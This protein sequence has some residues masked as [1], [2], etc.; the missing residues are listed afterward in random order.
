M[1]LDRDIAQVRRFSRFYTQHIG[2][3]GPSFLKPDMSLPEARLLHEIG[4]A[5]QMTAAT[6]ARDLALDPGYVSRLVKGLEERGL[7]ARVPSEQDGRKSFLT[8]TAAGKA[9]FADLER[10]SNAQTERLLAPLS[11]PERQAVVA[12]L[13]GALGLLSGGSKPEEPLLRGPKPGEGGWIVAAFSRAMIEE[14][15][16]A[17]EFEALICDIVAGAIRNTA[18]PRQKIW[19]AERGGAPVGTV[20]IVPV[21]GETAKLRLLVVTPEGRGFKLG[22]T[23]VAET[24]R[25]CRAAGYSRITLWTHAHLI[26]AR[27]IYAAAGFVCVGEERQHAFGRELVDETWVLDL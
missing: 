9:V 22:E 13:S 19:I 14:F 18:D 25:F 2:V 21:D 16:L 11:A 12:H 17:P 1:T 26:S 4:G 24:I 23:L 10:R 8:L 20:M 15:G 5:P 7:I 3:L 27:K 6:L